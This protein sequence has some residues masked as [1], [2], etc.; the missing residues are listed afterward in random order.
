MAEETQEIRY[1]VPRLTA[2]TKGREVLLAFDEDIGP[3]TSDAFCED[4]DAA[5]TYLARA[6]EIVRKNF[7]SMKPIQAMENFFK[8]TKEHQYHRLC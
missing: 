1:T 7:F 3:L 4:N 2:H 6:V 8:P 5:A